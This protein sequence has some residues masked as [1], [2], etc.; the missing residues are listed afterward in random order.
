MNILEEC[1]TKKKNLSTAWIDYKNAF[2]S[3]SHTWITK[4]L[5]I[6]QDLQCDRELHQIK[7][8]NLE[9]YSAPQA[10]QRNNNIKPH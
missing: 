2:D 10:R 8:E 7:Y 6:L 1:K 5:Q 3:V 9:D 4:C